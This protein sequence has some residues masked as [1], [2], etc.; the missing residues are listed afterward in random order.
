MKGFTALVTIFSLVAVL[1]AQE[2]KNP[3]QRELEYEIMAPCCYGSP[4]GDHESE[5]AQQVKVQ[6]AQLLA[7]GKTK[8]EIL[9]MYVAIYGERILAR[10]RAQGF[11]LMAYIV[12]PL[13][14]VVGGLFLFYYLNRVTSPAA[15]PVSA[16]RESYSDEFFSKIEKEM[17]ELDI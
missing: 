16:N 1:P 12:P 17:K 7:E 15:R 8:E 13:L 9:D 3:L 6:I 11:N 10:P 5:A 14:L 4:V 2:A